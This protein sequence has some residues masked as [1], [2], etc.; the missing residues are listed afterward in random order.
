MK[1]TCKQAATHLAANF[2]THPL[3]EEISESATYSTAV[4]ICQ[5][6]GETAERLTLVPEFEYVGCDDCMEE[7]LKLIA[8]EQVQPKPARMER[9]QGDPFPEVA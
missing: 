6:C 9:Q 3:A 4:H 5:N 8:R 2:S 1:R 7:A